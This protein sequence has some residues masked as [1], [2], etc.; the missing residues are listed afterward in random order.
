MSSN[1]LLD[2]SFFIRLL[3]DDDMLHENAVGYYKYFLENNI[4]MKIST[5]SVAEYC[6][7][8]S[9]DELPLRNL[10]VLTFNIDH[11]EKTG[12]FARIIF[13][14]KDKLTD[15]K[16]RVIIPNDSK[17]FAQAHCDITVTHFVTSDKKSMSIIG[18]LKNRTKINFDFMDISIPY[19]QSFGLLNF[20]N[21][22]A[23]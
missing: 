8:G 14:E 21:K 11:A 9:I 10:Q 22:T 18:L 16:E 23:E 12:E 13:S 20:N 6:V 5:I 2:T 3:N 17:L 19:S 7:K 4:I 15:I 1:V